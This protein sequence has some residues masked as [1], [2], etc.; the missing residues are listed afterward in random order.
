MDRRR[1]TGDE[2]PPLGAREHLVELASHRPLARGVSF[3]FDVG[4]I[5]K[6][7]QHALFAVL[8]ERVEVKHLVVC[9]SG[10]HLEITCVNEHPERRVDGQRNTIYKTMRDVNWMNGE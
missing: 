9:G 3:T 2:Q 10:V 1:K 6:K 7:R 4:R 5:L 8:R